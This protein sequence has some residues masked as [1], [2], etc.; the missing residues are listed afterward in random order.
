MGQFRVGFTVRGMNRMF[1]EDIE[2]D[3]ELD[4]DNIKE[5]IN[6][7]LVVCGIEGMVD[8]ILLIIDLDLVESRDKSE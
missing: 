2:L 5:V 4:E 6:K 7:R 3:Y 1:M 8:N